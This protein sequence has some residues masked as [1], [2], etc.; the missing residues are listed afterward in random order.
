[1]SLEVGLFC[2]FHRKLVERIND[3]GSTLTAMHPTGYVGVDRRQDGRPSALMAFCA[4]NAG[5][6]VFMDRL[7]L[8]WI[9][10]VQYPSSG[11]PPLEERLADPP[12]S[13]QRLEPPTSGGS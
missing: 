13:V 6:P 12:R 7:R 4:L 9:K 8:M 3:S 1:M 2:V 10:T 11:G 5:H